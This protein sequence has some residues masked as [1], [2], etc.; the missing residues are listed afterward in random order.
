MLLYLL[1]S[2]IYGQSNQPVAVFGTVSDESDGERI[3]GAAIFVPRLGIGTYTDAQ[4]YYTLQSELL[5]NETAIVSYPG[6]VMD[7][8]RLAAGRNDLT[9]VGALSDAI[10]VTAGRVTQMPT[11]AKNYSIKEL[12]RIP[13]LLGE[14][15]LI[16]S[17]VFSAGIQ[18]GAEGTSG[19]NVRG[20]SDDQNLYLLDGSTI[21]NP[22]HVFGFLTLFHPATVKSLTLYKGYIPSRFSGRLSSVVDVGIKDGN[23]DTIQWEASIGPVTNTILVEGP[24]AGG[25][26]DNLKSYVLAGR[27]VNSAVPTLVSHAVG[28]I[29]ENE[30]RIIAGM[31][32]L[33]AK[34]TNRYKNNA[35]LNLSLYFGDDLWGGKAVSVND[36]VSGE[37]VIWG[38]KV[39]AARYHRPISPNLV[40]EALMNGNFY[41]NSYRTFE[42]DDVVQKEVTNSG[43]VGEFRTLH[44]LNWTKKKFVLN[45]GIELT[46]Q[47]SRPLKLSFVD[48][49]QVSSFGNDRFASSSLR[50]FLEGKYMITPYLTLHAG[51]SLAHLLN[52]SAD[53]RT[54]YVEP[55]I[56]SSIKLGDWLTLGASYT[57]T[58]QPMHRISSLTAGLPYDIWFPATASIPVE[59]A[60]Q[61]SAEVSINGDRASL[62]VGGY[63]KSM[64]NLVEAPTTGVIPTGGSGM[65]QGGLDQIISGGQGEA[66]GGE[67]SI[68]I[69][70]GLGSSTFN[71]TY[72]RSYRTFASLNEGRRFAFDFDRPHTLNVGQQITLPNKWEANA[73][74]ALSS[75]RPITFPGATRTDLFGFLTL[76]Y[77]ETNNA[78]LSAYHRLDISFTK[79]FVTKKKKRNAKLT[80]GVYNIYARD[81]PVRVF[82]DEAS[83]DD[84]GFL[85]GLQGYDVITQ[86]ALQFIP[87]INYGLA[88]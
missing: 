40:Y 44:R 6:Y 42:R 9:L 50:T 74:F 2:S 51:V 78:R 85:G 32:D 26:P 5:G 75:G 70:S 30:Q 65:V 53:Y 82:I 45:P 12:E 84:A 79:R 16:K 21:Y 38:N 61:L 20:G 17:L 7:T 3:V 47:W 11:G 63:W 54:T 46:Q 72:S 13:A 27:L 28:G 10:L 52:V 59:K 41:Q 58:V 35:T 4:G 1:C 25:N 24:I 66:Y 71:Y 81:N 15:D 8:V 86:S 64:A 55:R 87:S 48:G 29:G 62:L 31:Y 34:Y 14:P 23:L 37:R 60:D 57:R 73:L 39:A 22:N 36:G 80:F 19:L 33:T 56:G 83:S 67:L 77:S 49:P 18:E 68:T 76:D 88:W 43:Q 69:A